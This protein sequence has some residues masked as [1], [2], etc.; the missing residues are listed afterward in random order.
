[1]TP[2]GNSDR[3]RL[4]TDHEA[5]ELLADIRTR[6]GEV[7]GFI[8]FQRQSDAEGFAAVV[9][10]LQLTTENDRTVWCLSF[11]GGDQFLLREDDIFRA[12][13]AH[14]LERLERDDRGD[15]D[16]EEPS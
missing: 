14:H 2:S 11:E 1:M 9:A 10:I 16:R 15:T 8:A 7:G 4:V 6:V 3:L 12:M 5:E 13:A